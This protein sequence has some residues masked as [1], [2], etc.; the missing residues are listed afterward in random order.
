MLMMQF[1]K[2]HLNISCTKSQRRHELTTKPKLESLVFNHPPLFQRFLYNH[3]KVF[4]L[5]I[6]ILLHMYLYRS[7]RTQSVLYHFKTIFNQNG[8]YCTICIYCTL[9]SP[10]YI[11]LND[12]CDIVPC[13]RL[14]F[15]KNV[16][17][18]YRYILS[19]IKSQIILNS[20]KLINQV[21]NKQKIHKDI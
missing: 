11:S 17:Q 8:A 5:N 12:S 1:R 18:Q 21:Q 10:S 2:K 20:E 13:C 3:T 7:C 6:S 19:W 15:A 9:K 4:L 16:F 14:I